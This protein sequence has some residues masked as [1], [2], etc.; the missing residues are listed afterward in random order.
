METGVAKVRDKHGDKPFELDEQMFPRIGLRTFEMLFEID[1]FFCVRLF[2]ILY[3]YNF[4][5][6]LF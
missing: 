4:F 2:L 5:Q 6:Y 1:K 3:Y